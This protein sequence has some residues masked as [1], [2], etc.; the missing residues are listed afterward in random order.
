MVYVV[1]N[2]ADETVKDYQSAIRFAGE[3]LLKVNNIKSDYIQACIDREVDF[4]T[5]LSLAS[6]QGV[7]MPHGNSDFVTE[8]SVSVVRLSEPVVFGLMEDKN[9]KVGVTL[10]FNLALSSGKQH[11]AVLRKVI[12]L[13]QDDVFIKK[14][15]KNSVEEVA[16]NI[17]AKLDS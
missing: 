16:S 2:D 13:F 11:M 3:A 5:G 6:G 9:Q 8:D 1:V 10:V 12:A 14:C 15:Q 7:A 17:K 4:P